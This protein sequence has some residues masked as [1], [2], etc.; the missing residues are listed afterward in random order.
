MAEVP[1]IDSTAAL[2]VG[3][4]VLPAGPAVSAGAAEQVVAGLH[5]AAARSEPYVREVTGLDEDASGPVR[6]VDRTSWLR[7]NIEMTTDMLRTIAPVPTRPVGAARRLAARANGAQLGGVFAL[8]GSR[9]LG[10]WL[11]F[12]PTPQLVL[13]APNILQAESQMRVRPADFRLWVCLHEQTHRLQ[14]AR[15]RWLTDHLLGE[16]RRLIDVGESGEESRR[17]R[18]AL[19][20]VLTGDQRVVFDRV[21]AV[22]SLLEGYA[23]VM[24]DRVGPRVIP[25]VAAI[26]RRF[27]ARRN[28]GGLTRAV[29]RIFGLDLK[30]AQ[31][32]DGARF[33][34]AVLDRVGV[35]GLNVVYDGPEQLP[36]AAELAAPE[37]WLQRVHR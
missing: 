13:V 15:A 17:P 10:Q 23:E 22:M 37:L 25:S 28:R 24:M 36:T 14:F 1:L 3:R 5:R 26:R 2:R 20:T 9:I 35:A 12:L 8:L 11:P 29:N 30:L 34:G 33:C 16:A 19:D 27:E 4:T 6:V 18:N 32:R 31:Y 21:S 7:L